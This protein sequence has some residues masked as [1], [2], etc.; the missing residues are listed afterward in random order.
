MYDDDNDLNGGH[1]LRAVR[2]LTHGWLQD[3]QTSLSL[4]TRLAGPGRPSFLRDF[5]GADRDDFDD[6]DDRHDLDE[7]GDA[8]PRPEPGA[9]AA[10][11]AGTS[12]QPLGRA[13]RAFPIVGALI[14]LVGGIAFVIADGLGLPGLVA[15][16]IAVAI[17]ALLT[18]ALHED[19]LAD[20]ADGFGGGRTRDDKLRLMRDS[21][22]GAYGVLALLLVIA[23]KVGAIADLKSVGAAIAAL[24]AAG[25]TSR[26]A[27]PALMRW[28]PPARA[29][30]LSAMAGKPDRE[31]VWTGFA[32]AVVISVVLLSWTGVVALLAAAAGG[33]LVAWLAK[34]QIGGQ[35]GD[36]LGGA[37]QVTE[38]LFL[39]GLAAV[40]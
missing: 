25:A 36:V 26:A 33:L 18:G 34:R 35:T 30:G 12:P 28:I 40:R 38:L 2:R 21:R 20:M 1:A 9:A 4:L 39:L 14:G 32:I 3:L 24:I 11:T 31:H 22:I 7:F 6:L 16:L 5:A 27:L 8:A 10:E 17:T 29:D 19:G 37:Q 15:A 13:A 23:I